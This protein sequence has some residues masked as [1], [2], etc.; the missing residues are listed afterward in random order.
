MEYIGDR[1]DSYITMRSEILNGLSRMTRICEKLDLT[2][3]AESLMDSHRK[4]QEHRFIGN[5]SALCPVIS[6]QKRREKQWQI[7]RI[8]IPATMP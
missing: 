6:K 5:S 4:L 1:Y 7:L 8:F 2:E 3:R